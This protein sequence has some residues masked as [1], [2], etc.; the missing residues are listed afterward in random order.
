MPG[1]AAAL[2]LAGLICLLVTFSLFVPVEAIHSNTQTV[3]VTATPAVSR[4]DLLKMLLQTAVFDLSLF[5]LFGLFLYVASYKGRVG[6]P[7]GTG[8]TTRLGSRNTSGPPRAEVMPMQLW[9]DLDSTSVPVRE[10]TR[11]QRSDSVPPPKSSFES[12]DAEAQPGNPDGALADEGGTV[13]KHVPLKME[14]PI[15]APEPAERF[16][17]VTELRYAFEVFLVAYLPTSLLRFVIINLMIAVTGEQPASHPFLELMDKEL[18][19]TILG[20][21]LLMAVVT[22]PIVEEL[23]YRV[24]IL[25][26]LAQFNHARSGLV[27]SS[28]IFC[29][30]HGFPDSLSL[31]PL[32]FALGFT[33]LRRRSYITVMLVHFLFNAFNMLVAGL[34]IMP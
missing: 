19:P 22:A 23:F 34:A 11:Q 9:P 10:T 6:I 2:V 30:A 16:S 26:G 24:V 17:F 29:M 28:I 5:G 13:P 32:A 33:Y 3:P 15:P 8:T 12:P 20:L 18:D 31:L 7:S 21:I 27:G 14:L 25:G 1:L 4:D